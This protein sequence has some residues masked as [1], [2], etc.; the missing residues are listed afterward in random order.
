MKPAWGEAAT[1]GGGDPLGGVPLLTPLGLLVTPLVELPGS[2]YPCPLLWLPP[3]AKSMGSISNCCPLE[4][5][6]YS[7]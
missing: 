3:M 7:M 5:M 2:P 1:G 4:A 6:Y